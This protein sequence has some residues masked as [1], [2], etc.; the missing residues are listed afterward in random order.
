MQVNRQHIF[1]QGVNFKNLIIRETKYVPF[2]YNLII[3][4]YKMYCL[5]FGNEI[6]K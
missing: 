1:K 3:D 2:T 6:K 4:V 5:E